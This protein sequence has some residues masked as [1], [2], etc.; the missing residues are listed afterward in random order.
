M[1]EPP[2]RPLAVE[3]VHMVGEPVAIVLA[4][5]LP[6]AQEA[7]ALPAAPTIEMKGLLR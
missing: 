4:T 1:P 6:A 5:T 3:G 7:A 2:F